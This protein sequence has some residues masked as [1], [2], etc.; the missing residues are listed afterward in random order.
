METAAFFFGVFFGVVIA[1]IT[2]K[3]TIGRNAQ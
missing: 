2:Y 3:V 1:Y